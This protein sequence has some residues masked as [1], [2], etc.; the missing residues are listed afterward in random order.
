MDIRMKNGDGNMT[1]LG[2]PRCARNDM[3][4]VF[5]R[6]IEIEKEE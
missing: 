6:G 3:M 5:D 1:V 4:Q 2:I